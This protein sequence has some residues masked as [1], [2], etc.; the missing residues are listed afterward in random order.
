[1]IAIVVHGGAGG[2]SPVARRGCRKAAEIGM[3]ILWK[4]GSA[5]D[6]SVAAVEWM[7]NSGNFNA[8]R[9]S[10]LRED[11]KTIQMDAA[12]AFFNGAEVLQG[13]V[14][15][16][17]NIRN[18]VLLALEIMKSPH[19]E[20]AGSGAAAFA[21][22]VGLLPHPGPS[23][24]ALQRYQRLREAIERGELSTA[25]PGWT[26][27]AYERYFGDSEQEENGASSLA[28]SGKECDTVG[29][30][31]L[32]RSGRV[33]TSAS[34]GGMN[35]MLSGRVGDVANRG[36]GFQIG[37]RGGVLA[38][39]VGEEIIRQEGSGKVFQLIQVGLHPQQACEQVVKLFD[40]KFPVGFIALT[41]DGVAGIASN[42]D[43]PS[44]SIVEQ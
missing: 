40:L 18:P 17:E 39:G 1:M 16:V 28:A 7:E 33:A 8:G 30:I 29:A 11:G 42:R 12:V 34:T 35:L 9:G 5:L 25:A 31:A 37:P 38:T 24:L 6:A 32:D 23:R 13:L 41:I 27:E 22:K 2:T 26:P 14:V 36:A 3:E 43:M 44:Y 15:A 21:E 20:L 19:L 10:V 4:G